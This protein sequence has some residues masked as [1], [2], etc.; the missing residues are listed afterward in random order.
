MHIDRS[1]L[2]SPVYLGAVTVLLLVSSAH[3]WAQESAI[4][5]VAAGR[6]EQSMAYLGAQEK[7]EVKASM[8]SEVVLD[9]EQKIQYDSAG[10]LSIHRPNKLNAHRTGELV[11]QDFIY[12]GETLT[13]YSPVDKYY[14]TVDAPDNL[15]G[16]LD[17]SM[18]TLGIIAPAADLLYSNAYQGLM[19]NVMSGFVVGEVELHGVMCDHLAFRD[20]LVDWQIWIAQGDRPLPM[21]MVITTLD[22]PNAPQ[23]SVVMTDWNLHPLFLEGKFKFTPPKDAVRIDFL[24]AQL[25]SVK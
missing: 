6:L 4:D 14:A 25:E 15:D 24:G 18:A 5:P 8:T 16:M 3:L 20:G 21:K 10:V 11:E 17:F 9:S 7:F 22:V 1:I 12:D 2:K 19:E 23:F 13:L